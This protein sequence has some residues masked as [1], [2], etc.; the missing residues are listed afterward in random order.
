MQNDRVI[1]GRDLQ[2]YQHI[3]EIMCG[4]CH[5]VSNYFIDMVL[6][7]EER[8]KELIEIVYT[9]KYCTECG[10]RLNY[11]LYDAAKEILGRE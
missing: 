8:D 10:K 4:K 11:A 6:S 2:K 7:K 1:F 3:I 5:H 9:H